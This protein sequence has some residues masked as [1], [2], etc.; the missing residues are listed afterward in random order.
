MHV[1][2]RFGERIAKVFNSGDEVSS[3]VKE[4]TERWRCAGFLGRPEYK[5]YYYGDC[6][7]TWPARLFTELDADIARVYA[8]AK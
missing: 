1:L 7:T 6:I 5:H 8:A 4:D 2:I 3:W